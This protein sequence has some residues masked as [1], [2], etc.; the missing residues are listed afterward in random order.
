MRLNYY[1]TKTNPA[2]PPKLMVARGIWSTKKTRK[3]NKNDAK[4]QQKNEWENNPVYANAMLLSQAR[5]D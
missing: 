5:R 4:I 1:H 2:K 3:S